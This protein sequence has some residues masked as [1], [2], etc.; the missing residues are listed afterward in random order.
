[1][2]ADVNSPSEPQLA[3]C[4]RLV[5]SDPSLAAARLREF[6]ED[7]PLSADAYRLLAR[8][9]RAIAEAA[10]AGGGIKS[11][12]VSGAQMRLQHAARALHADDLETAEI[13]LRQRL[14]QAPADVDALRLMAT[15]ATSLYF[16]AEAEQLLRLALEIAPDY[17]DAALD[18]GRELYD[19]NR[20]LEA[21]A[22][23]NEIL[24]R[25][26]E[27][28]RARMLKAAASGRAGR[29]D[30]SIRLYEE[31]LERSP[32]QA[33]L[34]TN[35]GH[36]LKTVGRADDGQRAMRRA[37][38]ISPHSGEAWWN[39]SN[40]KTTVFD[41]SDID[42]MY[43]ALKSD[44][45]SDQDQLQIH[46]ALGKAFEDLRDAP[47]AF[48][49]YS[50]ANRIR[51]Q[52]IDHDPDRLSQ[53]VSAARRFF[54]SEFFERRRDQGCE[55]ADP[56]FVIGMPRSGST[57]IE[58]ILASHPSVEGT[59]ELPDI[60]TL[61][62]RL[63]R[64]GSDYL[65]NL[66]NL[67]P[68]ELRSTGEDYLR[69]TRRYRSESRPHFI[70]KMPN[71]WMH[72]PL[73]HLILPNAKIID[74]RR[75][76][77]ACGFSN[78]KQHFVRGQTFSYDLNWMGR[79]YSDYV[80]LMAHVDAV[81][82]GRM[83][84]VIHERLVDDTESEVRRLLDYLGLPFDEACLRFY[85]SKRAV[86]TPS[87]EQVRRPIDR[88]SVEQWRAYEKFLGPLQDA[89]GDVLACYPGVPEFPD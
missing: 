35:Y 87:S 33:S 72:V 56:I 67:T 55:A 82:P 40:L 81:L 78:F 88:S 57:L 27:N 36:I 3:D 79:Y 44:D 28:E 11:S 69:L 23:A 59:M 54:S 80:R 65:R 60:A 29:F 43:A 26:R 5:E 2:N 16:R 48:A 46:F 66:G 18:L 64:G 85:E 62:K 51:R 74:A 15:L 52:T 13:I 12:V 10:P 25:D 71:N 1:L 68:D 49:H 70:D 19:Q 4:A 63:G 20:P 76:P 41:R 47:K 31:L 73:I 14:R 7:N 77:M 9:D 24:E 83:H 53:D 6:L 17:T 21:L 37:I 39:L 8:A 32:R 42:A 34:W 50:E 61:A 38:H 30:E 89:L 22:I 86:R 75:H 84:R 58:Q 45:S